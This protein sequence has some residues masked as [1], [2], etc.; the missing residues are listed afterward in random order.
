MGD[1][2]VV[3]DS[4]G[5]FLLFNQRAERLLGI[6]H[7]ETSLA[8]WADDC[9]VLLGDRVTRL[10]AEDPLVRGMVERVETEIVLDNRAVH[11]LTVAVTATPLLRGKSITGSVALLRDV[12]ER[13]L[14]EQRLLQAQKM[15]AIGQLAGGVAHDFNNLL[16][17]IQ[18]CGELVRQ[19]LPEGVPMH[20]DMEQLLGATRRATTLT[21]QLLAFGRR[22][23]LLPRLAT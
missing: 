18:S 3:T 22:Q 6:S 9:G 19:D 17:V 5:K 13:R 10:P 2:V 21:R 20:E 23:V 8:R 16:A 1:G 11:N 7:T 12:T 4:S 15:E 14:L